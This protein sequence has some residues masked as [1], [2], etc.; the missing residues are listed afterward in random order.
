[1]PIQ[2]SIVGCPYELIP[3]LDAAFQRD[4]IFDF[5][6][7]HY[8]YGSTASLGELE[9]SNFI[10]YFFEMGS[11][12][13]KSLPLEQV[14]KAAN[15]ICIFKTKCQQS[16]LLEKLGFC[17][18]YEP[19]TLTEILDKVRDKLSSILK[20]TSTHTAE[21]Q[22][23][24]TLVFSSTNRY[25]MIEVEKL[26]AANSSGN[27]TTLFLKD[28]KQVTVTK[29]IGK[30]CKSLPTS[31]FFRV[32]HSY[33]VNRNYIQSILKQNQLTVVLSDKTRVPVSRRKKKEFISWLGQTA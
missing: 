33:V 23:E 3:R 26:V 4:P 8:T 20:S 1:L 30:V 24:R 7:H 16:R 17:V 27:Y 14:N 29:Q 5:S 2:I 25:I 19:F 21:A 15:S 12:E 13:S 31:T 10:M 9:N 28:N 11:L 32:H 18:V 6:L 22:E